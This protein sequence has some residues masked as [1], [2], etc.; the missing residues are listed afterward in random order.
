MDYRPQ[1][2]LRSLLKFVSLTIALVLVLAYVTFQARFLIIGP[3]IKLTTNTEPIYN[4]RIIE[5]AGTA[6]NVSA[7]TL[8]GRAIYTDERG[9]FSEPLVLENGYTI[10]TLH[11]EDRYGRTTTLTRSFVYRPASSINI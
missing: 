2:E 3:V 4:E 7:I 5:I 6:S 9:Y 11:A 10:M 8:N 1:L